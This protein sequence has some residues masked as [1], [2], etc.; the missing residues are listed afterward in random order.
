MLYRLRYNSV[1]W[2]WES[3]TAPAYIQ[4]ILQKLITL[5]RASELIIS[6]V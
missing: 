1:Q 6:S 5:S 2:G 3:Q 4:R